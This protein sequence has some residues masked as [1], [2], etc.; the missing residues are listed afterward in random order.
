MFKIAELHVTTAVGL[1]TLLEIQAGFGTIKIKDLG[2]QLA[3][4]Q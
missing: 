4:G 1:I 2:T 3:H